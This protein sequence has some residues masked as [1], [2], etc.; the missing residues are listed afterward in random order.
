MVETIKA[1]GYYRFSQED[2]QHGA[3]SI[4]NQR[5]MVSAYAKQ[6]GW[7]FVSDYC[8]D[9]VSGT[10]FDR[11]GFKAMLEDARNGLFNCL[12]VKDLSRLG[13]NHVQTDLHIESIFPALGIRFI[14]IGENIDSADRDS[15]ANDL[16]PFV[17]LF[18]DFYARQTS[19]KIRAVLAYQ[20]KEGKY[21]ATMAAYGY[22]KD[23]QDKHHLIID[24]E[25]AEIVRRIFQMRQ[26]KQSYLSIAKTLNIEGIPCPS[27]HYARKYGVENRPNYIKQWSTNAIIHIIR[28]PVYRGATANGKKSTIESL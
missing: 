7:E 6:R 27:E 13:R 2:A 15:T 12:I 26:S 10:T 14:A 20:A 9:G 4:D 5:A 11:T 19:Q 24:P 17:N 21:R 1:V 28:N 16:A 25:V 23:P 22:E 18:N 3:T 8:D